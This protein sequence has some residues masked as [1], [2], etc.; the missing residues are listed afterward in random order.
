ML[1]G[2]HPGEIQHAH[3]QCLAARAWGSRRGGKSI[4]NPALETADVSVN[5]HTLSTKGVLLAKVLPGPILLHCCTASDVKPRLSEKNW[6]SCLPLKASCQW[7]SQ[8]LLCNRSDRP[9]WVARKK[10][11]LS[12]ESTFLVSLIL[13]AQREWCM[14]ADF[15]QSTDKF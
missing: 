8:Y 14:K 9:P 1:V 11:D 10:L 5:S 3:P 4:G 13:F 6:D 15:L 2:E 12:G 7:A